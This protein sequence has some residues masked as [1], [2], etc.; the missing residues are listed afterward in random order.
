[1][2]SR[3]MFKW[4]VRFKCSLRFDP[5]INRVNNAGGR[6]PPEEGL[7]RLRMNGKIMLRCWS[8]QRRIRRFL[9]IESFF[10]LERHECSF[11]LVTGKDR[12]FL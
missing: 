7:P 9:F 5:G 12:K 11:Q 8:N 10:D 1:M 4:S 2:A 3:E 6:V